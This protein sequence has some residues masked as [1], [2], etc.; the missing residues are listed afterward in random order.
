MDLVCLKQICS[1]VLTES[2]IIKC[3]ITMFID[4]Y[5]K[6]HIISYYVLCMYKESY[7][8]IPGS[9]RSGCHGYAGATE[10]MAVL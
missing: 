7:L 3:Q 10:R 8:F 2:N 1:L 9:D 5:S 4:S 6:Q